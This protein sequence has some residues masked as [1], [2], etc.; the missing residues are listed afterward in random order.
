MVAD[1]CRGLRPLEPVPTGAEPRVPVLEGIQAGAFDIYGTLLISAAGDISLADESVSERAMEMAI[2]SLGD[3]GK[4]ME[5]GQLA[6]QYHSAIKHHQAKRKRE[7]VAHPEVEIRDVWKEVF[8][9]ANIS[10]EELEGAAIIYECAVNPVWLMPGVKELLIALK[11]ASLPLAVVSN[12]QFYTQPILEE[13]LGER[14]VD[15]GFDEDLL[16]WSFVAREGKPSSRLYQ[17]LVARLDGRG[18]DAG[19][20]FYL[21]NDFRKDIVPAGGVGFLT[22]L[23]AGDKRSLRVGD[24]NFDDAAAKA[25]AVITDLKQVR[26]VVKIG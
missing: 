9:G 17:D 20:T 23:F 19:K 14:L 3:C 8:H 21:G 24:T 16:M 13:L 6:E 25:D 15:L 2:G 11:G 10:D 7:G 26:E 1:V 5:A 12:A 18:I 22:G 4:T